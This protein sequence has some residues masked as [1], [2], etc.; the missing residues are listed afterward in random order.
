ML[1]RDFSGFPIKGFGNKRKDWLPE[2]VL[3]FYKSGEILEFFY[4]QRGFP[5]DLNLN[6]NQY[7]LTSQADNMIRS[8]VL[9]HPTI[10]RY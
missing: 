8:R 6:G 9:Y 1:T 7:V 5:V 3:E 4:D 2:A 10:L